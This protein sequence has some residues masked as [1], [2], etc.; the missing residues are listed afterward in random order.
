MLPVAEAPEVQPCLGAFPRAALSQAPG[1][2]GAAFPSTPRGSSSHNVPH[3]WLLDHTIKQREVDLKSTSD[4][5]GHSTPG[6]SAGLRH[7]FQRQGRRHPCLGFPNHTPELWPATSTAGL[8]VQTLGV[9]VLSP[10][11]WHTLLPY[12]RSERLERLSQVDPGLT[13]QLHQAGKTD[14]CCAEGSPDGCG[15]QYSLGQAER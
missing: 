10:P 4:R 6:F 7:Q 15:W 2:L 12:G 8:L 14:R 3:L 13:A 11:S 1:A 9:R 5:D